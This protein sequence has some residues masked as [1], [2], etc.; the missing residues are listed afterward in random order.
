MDARDARRLAH[1]GLLVFVADNLEIGAGQVT[2]DDLWERYQS[3]TPR[4][5]RTTRQALL[6][7][8]WAHYREHLRGG[9]F[10]YQPILK[11][12][13]LVYWGG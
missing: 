1:A 7:Y 5:L 9:Q 12:I 6:R 11:G 3:T 13:R 4:E 8:I 10:H 2:K